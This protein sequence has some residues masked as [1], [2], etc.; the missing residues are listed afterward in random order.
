MYGGMYVRSDAHMLVCMDLCLH[1]PSGMTEEQQ[2]VAV[3]QQSMPQRRREALQQQEELS[4]ESSPAGRTGSRNWREPSVLLTQ[5]C[6]NA[7]Y[8]E[9]GDPVNLGFPV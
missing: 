7:V 6:Y 4:H 3:M 8:S 1:V 2:M 9:F 5:D